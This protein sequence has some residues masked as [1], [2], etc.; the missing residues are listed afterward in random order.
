MLH[1]LYAAC[2]NQ[3]AQVTLKSAQNNMRWRRYLPAKVRVQPH[4]TKI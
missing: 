2:T 3:R 1:L 4:V